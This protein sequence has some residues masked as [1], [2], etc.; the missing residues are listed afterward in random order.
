M[1]M[2]KRS[3]LDQSGAGC[4]FLSVLPYW[5]NI[6]AG[7]LYEHGLGA[8]CL[9]LAPA[10]FTPLLGCRRL[11]SWEAPMADSVFSLAHGTPAEAEGVES[12]PLD[13]LLMG[14]G[15]EA[16]GWGLYSSARGLLWSSPVAT[17]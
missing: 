15:W 9:P 7:S 13:S 10:D 4:P 17:Q 16:A 12:D 14:C 3:S 2:S 5:S 6:L 11:H 1:A 8:G